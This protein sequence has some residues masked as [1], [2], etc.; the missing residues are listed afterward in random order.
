VGSAEAKQRA[1]E[2][3]LV[4]PE[5]ESGLAL[6]LAPAPVAPD[7]KVAQK[8]GDRLE[9]EEALGTVAVVRPASLGFWNHDASRPSRR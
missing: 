2:E 3:P 6:G 9:V 8:V 7:A 1:E 5:L 4:A